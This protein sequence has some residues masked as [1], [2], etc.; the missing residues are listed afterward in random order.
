[1]L[2]QLGLGGASAGGILLRVL[3]HLATER[4]QCCAPSNKIPSQRVCGIAT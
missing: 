1:L 3:A 2:G 4:K